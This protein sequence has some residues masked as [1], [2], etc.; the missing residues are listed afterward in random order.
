M[1]KALWMG[2]RLIPMMMLLCGAVA[3]TGCTGSTGSVLLPDAGPVRPALYIGGVAFFPQEVD[4]CGPASLASVLNYWGYTVSPS[5]IA[6]EIH[7]PT[8]RGS[9]SMDLW[10]YAH[11]RGLEARIQTGSIDWLES[12]LG[13]K[14]PVIAF[15]NRGLR[16]FPI[17]HFLVVVGL[18]PDSEF[19][20]AH[21]GRKRDA[22]IPFRRFLADWKKTGF[23][24]LL[25][26]SRAGARE[27]DGQS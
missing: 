20:I 1:Q 19:V 21:S 22:R 13:Q 16:L 15:L 8:R 12:Q 4:Q 5:E 23:W 11:R 17:G 3:A 10:T 2:R 27:E 14:R 9:L 18:D 7:L 6:A 25:V 26:T 24:A